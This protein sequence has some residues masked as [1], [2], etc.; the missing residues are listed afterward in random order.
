MFLFI[1]PPI[2]FKREMVEAVGIEPTIFKLQ[3]KKPTAQLPL[4]PLQ[5]YIK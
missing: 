4:S 2:S 1:Y 5:M 3:V